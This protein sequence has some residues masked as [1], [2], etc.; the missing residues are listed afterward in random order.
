MKRDGTL[1]PST[2]FIPGVVS[3]AA[4]SRRTLKHG[5]SFAMFDEF[6][7]VLE[8]EHSPAGLFHYDTRFLSRLH[9][10]LE[11]HRP[12]ML[13]STVQTDN[14]TLDVDLTNPDIFVDG[15]LA[16]AKDTFHVARAKFLWQAS[17]YELF[18]VTSYA[19]NPARLRLALEF[20]ADFADL[21]EIRGYQRTRRGA[22]RSELR[23][24][25][26]A[27]FVYD[28]VDGVPRTTRLCFSMNP[29]ALSTTRAEFDLELGA[30]ERRALSVTVHCEQGPAR[31]P[32]KRFFAAL[33]QARRT[34]AGARA[35]LPAIDSSNSVFNSVLSRSSAD[36]AMLMT[37]TPQGP[38][39]YAGVPWFSTAFGRDG[40]ITALE[41]LWFNPAMARGVLRFL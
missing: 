37:E 11:G 28:A 4:S 9:F 23:G 8:V 5:D 20:A 40:L 38:Y 36:L 6:G 17:C 34:S 24:P 18:T 35:G 39:P 26:E 27:A 2:V 32:E 41:M 12:L 33:R 31:S 3:L 22:V 19:E 13:S 1:A 14:L 15:E 16:L 7:D 21:F 29:T 25:A 30:R 10:T